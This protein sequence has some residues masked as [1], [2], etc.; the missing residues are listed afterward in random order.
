MN[1]TTPRLNDHSWYAVNCNHDTMELWCKTPPPQAPSGWILLDDIASHTCVPPSVA[2]SI[3]N[4]EA[5]TKA[6]LK[7]CANVVIGI[8]GVAR[9]LWG[10]GGLGDEARPALITLA[11]AL[12]R[13]LFTAAYII[14]SFRRL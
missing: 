8:L 6:V 4:K 13:F 1:C 5:A 3:I 10:Q 12:G 14:L 11:V 7:G 2:L 9:V